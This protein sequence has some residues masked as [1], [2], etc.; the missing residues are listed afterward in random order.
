MRRRP[1]RGAGTGRARRPRLLG[2]ATAAVIPHAQLVVYPDAGHGF[3]TQGWSAFSARVDRF[4][5]R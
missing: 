1:A 3:L 5:G 4:L 2:A